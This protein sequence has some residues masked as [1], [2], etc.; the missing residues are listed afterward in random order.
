[1]Q[2]LADPGTIMPL[3]LHQRLYAAVPAGERGQCIR[4]LLERELTERG[5]KPGRT[6]AA[7]QRLLENAG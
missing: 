4:R 6:R 3:S 7:E 2:Q 5:S 1:M